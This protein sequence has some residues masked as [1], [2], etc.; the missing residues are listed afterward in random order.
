MTVQFKENRKTYKVKRFPAS[1]AMNIK[2]EFLW[3]PLELVAVLAGG[4]TGAAPWVLPCLAASLWVHW[5]WWGG[6]RG[7]V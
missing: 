1:A 2:V 6:G 5:P 3:Q 7:L 4:G